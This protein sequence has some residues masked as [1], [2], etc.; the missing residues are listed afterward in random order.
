MQT[1]RSFEELAK[2]THKVCLAIGVFDGVH[3][4]HQRVIAQARDDARAVGGASVVLTFDPHPMRVLQPDKAPLLLTS[5]AH[6]LRLIEQLGVDACLLLTFDKPFSETPPEKFIELIV[7]NTNQL[8]EICVGTRFRF[9]HNRAGDVRLIEN[10][11]PVYGYIAREIESVKLGGEIISSTS[12]R[13]HILHGRLD[14]AAA[15]L[16]R[17]FSILGTVEKGDH[18]GHKLGYPT[19]NLNPHNEVLPPD[20]VYAVGVLIGG[21]QFGGVVN[22]G[23]RPTFADRPPQHLLEVHIF[24]FSRDIYGQDVEVV[25]LQKL[26]DERKFDSV[27]ALKSQIAA[28][29]QAARVIVHQF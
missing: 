22:I 7:H 1:V 2:I 18:T 15:M 3:L 6:K 11:A 16:G 20:G 17:P 27:D 14:R 19:A 10:L 21:K 9:G 4:G 8:Q 26:R 28:D 25:F 12:V 5:T 23:Y 24:D 29:E 13:Q